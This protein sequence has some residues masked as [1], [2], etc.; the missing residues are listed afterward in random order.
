MKDYLVEGTHEGT[1]TSTM[2]VV[3][4]GSVIEN[5]NGRGTGNDMTRN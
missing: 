3:N 4:M 1:E 2:N 5:E